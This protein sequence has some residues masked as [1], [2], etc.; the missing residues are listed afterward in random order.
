MSRCSDS[1]GGRCR[2]GRRRTRNRGGYSEVRGA[3][4]RGGLR[5]RQHRLHGR[6]LPCRSSRLRSGGGGHRRGERSD[7][8]RH[9]GRRRGRGC[10]SRHCGSRHCSNRHC[11]SRYCGRRHGSRR[12]RGDR[13]GGSGPFGCARGGRRRRRRG[14]RSEGWGR[15]APCHCNDA[16]R[17]NDVGA[18]S[19]GN[20][21]NAWRRRIARGRRQPS[22]VGWRGHRGWRGNPH[23]R[24][25]EARFGGFFSLG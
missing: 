10:G 13:C 11:G 14:A 16:R 12:H 8:R 23:H 4:W 5:W 9:G 15:V 21:G 17:D 1:Q 18:R 22:G 3:E 2:R 25:T 6:Y 20:V 24:A 19:G 7:G